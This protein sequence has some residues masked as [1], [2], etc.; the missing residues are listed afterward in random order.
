MNGSSHPKYGRRQLVENIF[1]VLKRK[2]SGDLKA[3]MFLVQKKEIANKKIVWNIHNS[4]NLSYLRFFTKQKNLGAK[5]TL[6]PYSF[7]A[8]NVTRR[9]LNIKSQPRLMISSF[10]AV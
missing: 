6:Y 8:E 7:M 1:S 4:Y 10:F 2:F 5:I 9:V 3:R